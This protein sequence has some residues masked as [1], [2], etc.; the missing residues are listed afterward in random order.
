LSLRGGSKLRLE[1]L[2]NEE[3]HD[4]IFTK[5]YLGDYVKEYQMGGVCGTFEGEGICIESFGG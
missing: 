5:Y 4:I 2:H 1:K 3:P